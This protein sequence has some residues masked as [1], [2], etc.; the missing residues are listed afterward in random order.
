MPPARSGWASG[1]PSF[2]RMCSSCS[3]RSS[4]TSS[5]SRNSPRRRRRSAACGCRWRSARTPRA[6]A[7][8]GGC[9]ASRAPARPRWRRQ[10]NRA[11]PT[12]PP[13][14]RA[15]PRRSRRLPA[16]G[17]VEQVGDLDVAADV[18]AAAGVA[19]PLVHRRLD[20]APSRAAR[21][22]TRF[23]PHRGRSRS[24]PRDRSP[25]RRRGS[26]PPA[27]Q[28][29]ASRTSAEASSNCSSSFSSKFSPV[30]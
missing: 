2:C 21:P 17:E 13:A 9:G 18:V 23:L 19:D 24:S 20:R 11:A 22:P 3:S 7:G 1:P 16:H 8:A 15:A 5:P 14:W 10:R 4:G 28:R 25:R 12:D 29:Q 6:G 30:P 27:A 26:G